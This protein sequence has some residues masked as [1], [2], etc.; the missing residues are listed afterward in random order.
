MKAGNLRS[1]AIWFLP[2]LVI[3]PGILLVTS[4][5][6]AVR[7]LYLGLATISWRFL[8]ARLG[9][10]SFGHIGFVVLG[11]YASALCMTKL[12]LGFVPATLLTLVIVGVS[13]LVMG[14]IS[15]KIRGIFYVILTYGFLQLIVDLANGTPQLT[16]GGFGMAVPQVFPTLGPDQW[17]NYFVLG[18]ILVLVWFAGE[19]IVAHSHLGTNLAAIRDDED[20][21]RVLGMNTLMWKSTTNAYVAVWGGLAGAFYGNFVG[22]ITPVMGQDVVQGMVIA[23]AVIGG[24]HSL[25]GVGIATVGL[26]ILHSELQATAQAYSEVAIGVAALV[27]VVMFPTGLAGLARSVQAAVRSR[28]RGR[29]D[30]GE[31][32]RSDA[33]LQKVAT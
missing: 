24:L 25:A 31:V 27:A 19:Y 26:V 3:C 5:D 13:G 20:E 17:K 7:V 22:Y 14:L 9:V 29:D 4:G 30:E 1:F 28:T 12:G 32:Q 18:L 8:A 33:P 6:V 23:F 10:F 2:I 21:A 15:M 16:G 11:A